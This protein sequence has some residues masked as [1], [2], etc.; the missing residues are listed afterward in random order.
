[1][2]SDETR[3]WTSEYTV[4]RTEIVAEVPD[5]RVVDITLAP[6]ECVPWHWHSR[7]TDR[8]VCLEGHLKVETRGP[9][10]TFFLDP[11]GRCEVPAGRVHRV[12]GAGEGRA[13]F[14]VIQGVGAYDYRAAGD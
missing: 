7:V 1:M 2:S 11:G 3:P 13:R 6:G 12:S 8:F 9:R 14:L 10:E 4:T 5:L